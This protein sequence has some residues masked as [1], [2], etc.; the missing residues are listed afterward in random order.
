MGFG[1]PNDFV[2]QRYF[3]RNCYHQPNTGGT[4]TRQNGFAVGV[5]SV[6]VQMAMAVY[7]H[8]RFLKY[9]SLDILP[10]IDCQRRAGNAFAQ[11]SGQQ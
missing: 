6:E 11:W 4:R 9:A 2:G 1:E 10:V 5:K 7:K 3:G 8:V